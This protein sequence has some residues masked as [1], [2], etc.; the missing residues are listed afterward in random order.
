[1]VGLWGFPA[2]RGKCEELAGFEAKHV[3]Q[4]SDAGAAVWF[5]RIVR[6]PG[7]SV[8]RIWKSWQPIRLDGCCDFSGE[9][10]SP[11]KLERYNIVVLNGTATNG[12]FGVNGKSTS[13]SVSV[14]CSAKTR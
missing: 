1:M 7:G 13:L 6:S 8:R 2:V 14:R 9:L 12:S 4:A 5:E 10:A 11:S 3:P